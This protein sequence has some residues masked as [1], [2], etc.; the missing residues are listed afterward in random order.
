M[1]HHWP[2]LIKCWSPPPPGWP[3]RSPQGAAPSLS[4]PPAWPP[5]FRGF[6]GRARGLSGAARLGPTAASVLGPHRGPQPW[7]GGTVPEAHNQGRAARSR[8][9]TCRGER[10]D[11]RNSSPGTERGATVAEAAGQG[12]S[13]TQGFV[14][15][16][17]RRGSWNVFREDSSGGRTLSGQ[18]GGLSVTARS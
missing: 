3:G 6:L 7:K 4:W 2:A 1:R 17:G 14:G 15:G 8:R 12:W 10:R 13:E 11:G 18:N 5:F 9:V 16:G